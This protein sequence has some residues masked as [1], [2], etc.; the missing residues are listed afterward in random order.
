[1]CETQRLRRK[2]EGEIAKLQDMA[3]KT[4]QNKTQ[5]ERKHLQHTRAHRFDTRDGSSHLHPP[6]SQG[7]R[8]DTTMGKPALPLRRL[9][10]PRFH[11]LRDLGSSRDPPVSLCPKTRT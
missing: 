1:M 7:R 2:A 5:E 9:R 10:A 4:L 11:R 6:S 3:G 8:G